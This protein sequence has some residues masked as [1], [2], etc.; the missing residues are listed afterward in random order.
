MLKSQTTKHLDQLNEE[1]L[2]ELVAKE[3][4]EGTKSP[5]LAAKANA[6]SEGDATKAESLYIRYRVEALKLRDAALD[7]QSKIELKEDLPSKVKE[8]SK[9]VGWLVLSLLLG[10]AALI[11]GGI[12]ADIVKAVFFA[13][14]KFE[15]YAAVGVFGL[16]CWI[17][18]VV[19]RLAERKLLSIDSGGTVPLG[20]LLVIGI[21]YINYVLIPNA[22][23]AE[24]VPWWLTQLVIPGIA[25]FIAIGTVKGAVAGRD[26]YRTWSGWD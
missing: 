3:I 25:L 11:F 26:K 17:L 2:Y 13:P 21:L 15:A 18:I 4:A 22:V 9:A 20:V 7:E 10:L 1:A 24:P 19:L 6:N 14:G 5:G 8:T 12:A 16:G 23:T